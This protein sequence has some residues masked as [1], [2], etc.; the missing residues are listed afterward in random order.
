[1]TRFVTHFMKNVLGEN[2]REKEICQRIVEVDAASE[3]DALTLAKQ[4]F[5]E[6][7]RVSHWSHHADRMHVK[8]ADFPS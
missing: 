1:M 4:K 5:C 6:T 3:T 8:E 7:E 2:G